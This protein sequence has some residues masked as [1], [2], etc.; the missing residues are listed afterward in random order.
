M[1]ITQLKRNIIFQTSIVGFH[2]NLSGCIA[3][4]SLHTFQYKKSLICVAFALLLRNA[5]A[6]SSLT[7]CGLAGEHKSLLRW[8]RWGQKWI[9]LQSFCLRQLGLAVG[10]FRNFPGKKKNEH[11][12]FFLAHRSGDRLIPVI[13]PFELIVGFYMWAPL[14]V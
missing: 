14:N 8:S 3:L 11:Q 7:F 6:R 9:Y 5:A 1:K 13:R 12:I 2:V 10:R 4:W